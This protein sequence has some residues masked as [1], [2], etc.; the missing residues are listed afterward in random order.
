MTSLGGWMATSL[1]AAVYP[2]MATAQ[3]PCVAS[4]FDKP[5]PAAENVVT[6]YADV[7]AANFPG[8]WQEGQIHDYIY[9]L[10][11]DLTGTVG[12]PPR[13]NDWRVEVSCDEQARTCVT[14]PSDAAPELAVLIAEVLGR[15]LLGAN[16][17]AE[18]VESLWTT[19][20]V[21]PVPLPD[22]PPAVVE[23]EQIP[24][25][26]QDLAATLQDEEAERGA[27]IPPSFLL[28]EQSDETPDEQ[29]SDSEP[30]PLQ[31]LTSAQD[32]AT[33]EPALGAEALSEPSISSENGT[34]TDDTISVETLPESVSPTLDDAGTPQTET[35]ATL[36]SSDGDS[37]PNPSSNPRLE[38]PESEASP[39]PPADCGLQLVQE[40]PPVLTLQRL[41]VI[42]EQDPGPLDGLM[43]RRTGAALVAYLGPDAADLSIEEAIRQVDLELCNQ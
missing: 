18:A 17:T 41:L 33:T 9:Q 26:E 15:C 43:G 8:R 13:M 5:L 34:D 38:S 24:E 21:V 42:A 11:P 29:S 28:A 23:V 14:E 39:Q 32:E 22:A 12:S 25:P 4:A 31:P 10:F 20:E 1:L 35:V 36:P 40:G 16:I 19:P 2:L 37:N 30:R 3:A 27:A 6:R 7:P